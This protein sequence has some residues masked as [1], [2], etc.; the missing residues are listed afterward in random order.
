M[1]RH[2]KRNSSNT[3]AGKIKG[4]DNTEGK[5]RRWRINSLSPVSQR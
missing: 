1:N 3:D 2:N 4:T 5:G